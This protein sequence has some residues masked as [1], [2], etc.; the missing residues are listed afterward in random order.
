M[1]CNTGPNGHDAGNFQSNQGVDSG[2]VIPVCYGIDGEQNAVEDGFGTLVSREKGGGFEGAVAF[3]NTGKGYWKDGDITGKVRT[4]EGGDSL[5]S[6]IVAFTQNSRDEVRVIGEDG[7]ISG[8]LSA[9]TGTHQT[10][11]LAFDWYASQSQ[12]FPVTEECPPLKTT[13]QPAVAMIN[14]QGSKGNSVAQEDGPSFTLN[15]MHGHDVHAVAFHTSGYGGQVDKN[16]AQ[17][18]QASDAKLSN[19]V[20]GVIQKMQV[21]RLTPTECERLQGVP[22]G[23]TL[24]PFNGKPMADGNR[25]KM[26]GNGFAIPCVKWIGK[27]IQMVEDMLNEHS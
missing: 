26:I 7:D 27:R 3:Q 11:Y 13:M 2:Y 1:A 8:S 20:S 5:K 9:E 10:T 16:V 25:Y 15:A 4:P 14:M 23:H 22:D 12:N 24:V 17:T 19:Q 6:T 18:L 21:R